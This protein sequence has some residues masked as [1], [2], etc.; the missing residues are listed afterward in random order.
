MTA[1]ADPLEGGCACGAVRYRL[2]GAPIVTHACH[3]RKCQR[4]SGSAF[5][6]NAMIEADC[7]S[8]LGQTPEIVPTP[9]SLPEGQKA[10]RCPVCRVEVWS[11]HAAFGDG[12]V[13]LHVGTLDRGEAIAPD[14]HCYTASRHPWVIVPEDV[15]AFPQGYEPDEVWSDEVR[16][17]VERATEA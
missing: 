2:T 16:R 4:R 6:V 5:A 15:R 14:I 12:I 9:S 7:I 17:R 3:C 13:M 8:L 1:V 11:N 10:H